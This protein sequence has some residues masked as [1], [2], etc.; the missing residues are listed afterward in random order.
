MKGSKA[1]LVGVLLFFSLKTEATEFLCPIPTNFQNLACSG[2]E[3]VH[4]LV[5]LQNY[6]STLAIKNNKA[7]NLE[8]D[9]DITGANISI[10]TPCKVTIK[11]GRKVTLS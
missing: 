1:L 9:F 11:D 2:T 5:Q 4:T 3:K 8:I 7:K 10:V 6:I